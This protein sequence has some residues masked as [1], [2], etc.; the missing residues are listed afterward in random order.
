M[1]KLPGVGLGTPAGILLACL[2]PVLEPEARE[3][4]SSWAPAFRCPAGTEELWLLQTPD[5]PGPL[6]SCSGEQWARI[7]TM[8]CA[9]IAGSQHLR[10]PFPV[11][12]T[13][14]LWE[15]VAKADPSPL[16]SQ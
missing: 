2:W 4:R 12:Y 9:E 11:P 7:S 13:G 5:R 8:R 16:L 15:P 6:L 10:S 1:A 3:A 14:V